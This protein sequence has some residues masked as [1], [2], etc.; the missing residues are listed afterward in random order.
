M[1]ITVHLIKPLK[2]KVITYEG[3][4]LERDA[5]YILLYA[6]WIRPTMDLGYIVFEPGDTLYEH[7]YSDR[8]YNVYE[9]RSSA[10]LLKGWYCNITRPAVF[11]DDSIESED[12]E[13]DLFVSPDRQTM[14]VLDEEEYAARGLE[15][16][17]PDAHHAARAALDELQALA[18]QG[19]GPFQGLE[20]GKKNTAQN[21]T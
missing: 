13:L 11:T 12:V 5:T 4:L 2:D 14:L 6:Q 3:E 21:N 7:F 15:T 16:S 17:D 8:W 20:Y 18:K 9:V 10:E 1:R 19:K